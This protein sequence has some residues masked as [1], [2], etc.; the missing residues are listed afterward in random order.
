MNTE[1]EEGTEITTEEGTETKEQTTVTTTAPGTITEQNITQII[2]SFGIFADQDI[3]VLRLIAKYCEF[4]RCKGVIVSHWRILEMSQTITS[5]TIDCFSRIWIAIL[6]SNMLYVTGLNGVLLFVVSVPKMTSPRHI[7]IYGDKLV[8]T[9]FGSS[10]VMVA[11]LSADWLAFDCE[12]YPEIPSMKDNSPPQGNTNLGEIFQN[13]TATV[14]NYSFSPD[15]I[16]YLETSKRS[17]FEMM[18]GS[19]RTGSRNATRA[20]IH[21]PCG[22]IFAASA[23][24]HEQSVEIFVAFDINDSIIDVYDQHGKFLRSFNIMG[25]Q[26]N[27]DLCFD[28]ANRL[29]IA[30]PFMNLIQIVD[31]NGNIIMSK[32]LKGSCPM[33]VALS[34]T[35]EIFFNDAP[36][37]DIFKFNDNFEQQF[38]PIITGAV[39]FAFTPAGRIVTENN[40]IFCIFE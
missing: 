20:V 19:P 25:H 29:W 6:N 40:G 3:N 10:I 4:I 28:R 24:A 12:K 14:G 1:T 39:R 11:K 38:P 7:E 31:V 33:I 22:D 2:S 36:G 13:H 16:L 8:I 15:D 5:F 37:R 17:L 21:Q 9:Q 32:Y 30:D 23:S 34:P 27:F 26:R 35:G 18:V